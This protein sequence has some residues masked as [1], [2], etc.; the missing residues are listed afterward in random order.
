[1]NDD[2]DAFPLEPEEWAD[3]DHDLI[4]D[5]LDADIDGDGQGDDGNANG[6]PDHEE[7]DFDGDGM[8]RAN[9][10]PWDAFPG[11][12]KEHRDTD[13][14]GDRGQRRI[15]T[16]TETAFRTRKKCGPGPIRSIP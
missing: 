9:A 2:Q 3:R 16:T 10:V 6:T 7:L 15:W 13:G 5:N 1:M 8:P 14:D 11:D 12:P 4:G